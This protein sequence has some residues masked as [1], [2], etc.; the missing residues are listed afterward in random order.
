MGDSNESDPQLFGE[1]FPLEFELFD[2]DLSGEDIM[3]QLNLARPLN[4]G[5]FL[6]PELPPE[7]ANGTEALIDW[8]RP[9]HL[10]LNATD[11]AFPK[12]PRPPE[13]SFQILLPANETGVV[14]LVLWYQAPPL[15]FGEPLEEMEMFGW[16]ASGSSDLRGPISRVEGRLQPAA[17]RRC[18]CP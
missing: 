4:E 17:S 1:F 5:S 2:P 12:G 10:E 11:P 7:E 14:K 13:G 18:N 3:L 8:S 15:V 9:L 6:Y 16:R